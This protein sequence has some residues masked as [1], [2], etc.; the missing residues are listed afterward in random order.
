MKYVDEFRDPEKGAD[1]AEGNHR[2]VRASAIARH[3]PLQ[4]MEVCGGHT[5]AIFRY[6]IE[7]MLPDEIELVHGPGCPVCVLPMG[8]VDDCV[9]LADAERDLHHLRRRHARSRLEEKPAAGQERRRRCAH[10]L[11]AARC[12]DASP[13]KIP[14]KEV[15]FFALGFET[16]MPSTAI[17]RA[18]GGARGHSELFPVLQPHHHHSTIKAILD[19]PEL[20][21]DGFLGPGHVSMVIGTAPYEFIAEHYHKPIVVAGF[22]PLDILQSLWMVL[23]QLAEGRCEVE[24][25]YP[26]SCPKPATRRRWRRSAGLRVARVLRVARSRLD[27]SFRGAHRAS[28]RALRRRE[29]IRHPLSRSPI[30]NRASAAKSSRA[31]IKPWECKVFGTRLHAG[32][33]AGRIDGVYRRRL[34]RLLPVWRHPRVEQG[35]GGLRSPTPARPRRRRPT[36]SPQGHHGAW[37]RRQGHARSHRRRLRRRL[38]QPNT[39]DIEDQARFRLTDLAAHGDRLAMTTDSM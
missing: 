9:T 38:R 11:F 12:A 31:C 33:A 13:A 8:R 23:R 19:S 20:Q 5:H 30:R 37:R 35:R 18:A 36:L 24:N 25:Q 32:D 34:R 6:G 3:R 7:T 10:G 1:P 26:A 27:R 4:I 22:E 17:H 14:D 39:N 16:T 29:Q 15:V 28:L 2:P 21:L